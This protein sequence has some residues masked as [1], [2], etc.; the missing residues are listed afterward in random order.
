MCFSFSQKANAAFEG[1]DT[2]RPILDEL[3]RDLCSRLEKKE[4]KKKKKKEEEMGTHKLLYVKTMSGH[5]RFSFLFKFP[6]FKNPLLGGGG[7][8]GF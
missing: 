2:S 3:L 4:K 5:V 7:G 1:N 8:G 6:L